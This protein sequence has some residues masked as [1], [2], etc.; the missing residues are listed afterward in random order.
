VAVFLGQRRH[1]RSVVAMLYGLIGIIVLCVF[2]F[3]VYAVRKVAP[4]WI[5]IQTSIWKI[6]VFNLELGQRSD[7]PTGELEQSQD[8]RS[9]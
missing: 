5:R 1:K 3:S 2:I 6:A 4:S 8:K 7:K 9:A